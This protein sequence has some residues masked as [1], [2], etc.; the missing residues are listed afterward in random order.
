V[1]E[2]GSIRLVAVVDHSGAV[3]ARV[4]TYVTPRCYMLEGSLDD[5]PEAA[6]FAPMLASYRITERSCGAP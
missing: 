4:T 6:D 3:G 5:S 1:P 2:A